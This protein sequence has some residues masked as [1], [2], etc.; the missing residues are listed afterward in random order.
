[1]FEGRGTPVPVVRYHLGPRRSQGRS[2]DD[3]GG[4]HEGSE[5]EEEEEPT[6]KWVNEQRQFSNSG[7]YRRR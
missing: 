4:G 1:M 7:D 5:G 3:R 6:A 2:E